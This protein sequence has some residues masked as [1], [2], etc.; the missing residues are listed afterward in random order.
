MQHLLQAAFEIDVDELK[1]RLEVGAEIGGRQFHRTLENAAERLRLA[2]GH[3]KLAA[4]QV[5]CDGGAAELGAAEGDTRRR[6]TQIEIEAGQVVERER[7]PA[8][9]ALV[10]GEQPNG[11]I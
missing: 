8:P 5:G 4:A 11:R 10:A 9:I 2:D 3:G 1:L 7:Q 6:Q